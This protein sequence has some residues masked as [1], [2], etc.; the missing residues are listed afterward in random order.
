M[1]PD[2]EAAAAG[3]ALDTTRFAGQNSNRKGSKIE[4]LSRL[5]ETGKDGG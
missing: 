5:E 2:P 3:Q 1:T 4:E